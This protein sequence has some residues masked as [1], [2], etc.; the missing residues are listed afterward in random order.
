MGTTGRCI[1][2]KEDPN[3]PTC[4]FE[5]G[6][7]FGGGGEDS[8]DTGSNSK[9]GSKSGS[10]SGKSKKSRR[11]RRL[12]GDDDDEGDAGDDDA[13]QGDLIFSANCCTCECMEIP[14]SCE[15]Q[16]YID[17]EDA[18]V[19]N[20]ESASKDGKSKDGKSKKSRRRRNRKLQETG[21]TTETNNTDEAASQAS[22]L[23]KSSFNGPAESMPSQAPATS[24]HS[25]IVESLWTAEDELQSNHA[26]VQKES[27]VDFDVEEDTSFALEHKRNRRL[28]GDDDD[29]EDGGDT[30]DGD[31]DCTR[32]P[33]R[34]YYRKFFDDGD[35]PETNQKCKANT[36]G[37]CE[38]VT[39]T[40][41]PGV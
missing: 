23:R 30:D 34:C 1:C 24:W 13:S 40:R 11:N 2:E 14:C 20:R 26:D 27:H 17:P 39:P 12:T 10:K 18:T 22:G 8:G 33:Y 36:I 5:D 35:C 3:D 4:E 37:H 28:T 38:I 15:C 19:F 16:G 7:F 32:P 6:G 9:D 21:E 25:W 31:E 29:S 41:A